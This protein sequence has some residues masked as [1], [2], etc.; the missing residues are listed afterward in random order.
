MR[1]RLRKTLTT[2]RRFVERHSMLESEE[3]VVVAFSGGPDSRA[4]LDI[5]L[6]LRDSIQRRDSAADGSATKPLAIHIAHLDHQLRG[7]EST[8]DSDFVRETASKYAL[9][10]SVEQIDVGGEARRAHRRN[11]E[12]ARRPRY[13]VR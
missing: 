13:E 1:D 12:T 6:R 3:G 11:E 8:A 5:L 2:V 9:S 4:L 10:C 7:A